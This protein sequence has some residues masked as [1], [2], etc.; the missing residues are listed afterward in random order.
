MIEKKADGTPY[1]KAEYTE[2]SQKLVDDI[3]AMMT[4][5]GNGNN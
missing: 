1:T 2:I 4:E 3:Y 5:D